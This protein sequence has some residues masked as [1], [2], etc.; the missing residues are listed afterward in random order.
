MVKLKT[1]LKKN[2]LILVLLL[3]FGAKVAEWAFQY[4]F[5]KQILIESPIYLFIQI[6]FILAIAFILYTGFQYMKVKQKTYL[7]IPV[8]AYFLKEV[9]NFL[10]I[11]GGV[12]NLTTLIA[13]VL[14]PLSILG[15]IFMVIN[16]YWL[17]I[18]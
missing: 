12:I 8:L 1:K 4:T 13:L 17:K 18:K 3:T 10:F 9:F 2:P 5:T 6:I 11:Y 15:F 14:E 7:L 16:K